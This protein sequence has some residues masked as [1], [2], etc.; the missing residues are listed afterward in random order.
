MATLDVVTSANK[1]A[2]TVDLDPSIFEAP[3]K[4]H[5]FHAEVRRQLSLRRAGTH[6]T[7]NR[8]RVSGGGAKPY[9]QKGTGRARQG[10]TRAPQWAGGGAAFGPVPRKH[11]HGLSKKTR[12]AALISA[13]SL[14]VSEGAFTVIDALDLQEFKTQA[15]VQLLDGIG[16]AGASSLIVIAEASE[17]VEK[18]AAN[19]ARVG[20]I[21][22]EGL[23]VYDILRHDKLV[24]TKDAVA[25]LERRLNPSRGDEGSE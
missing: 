9:R 15:I 13:L 10:T 16:I 1:K 21:R 23:N 2:G 25:A 7:K 11:G 4:P 14:R 17:K 19:L 5:L 3:V 20:C 12:R 24:I 6:S 18:S 8:A 22:V